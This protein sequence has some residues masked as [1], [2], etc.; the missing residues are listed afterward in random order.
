MNTQSYEHIHI[1]PIFL[2]KHMIN[3]DTNIH[4]SIQPYEHMNAPYLYEYI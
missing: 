1:Y 3:I 2:E 4:T